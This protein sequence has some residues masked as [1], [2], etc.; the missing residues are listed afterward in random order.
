MSKYMYHLVK[1]TKKMMNFHL[2][3]I[4]DDE[5]FILPDKEGMQYLKRPPQ[6]V[7]CYYC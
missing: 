7:C 1:S 6:T 5:N 2:K 4:L 3:H